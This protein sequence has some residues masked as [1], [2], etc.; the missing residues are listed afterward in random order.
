MK[1]ALSLASKQG[2]GYDM[3]KSAASKDNT[4]WNPETD[5][6]N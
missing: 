6:H 3:C 2:N 5:C 4:Q 1:K